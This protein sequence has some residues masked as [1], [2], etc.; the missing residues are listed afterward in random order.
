MCSIQRQRHRPNGI[1]RNRRKDRE[2]DRQ[3]RFLRVNQAYVHIKKEAEAEGLRGTFCW[4]IV[5][6]SSQHVRI[7]VGHLVW[8][9]LAVWPQA[10]HGELCVCVCVCVRSLA[11]PDRT[12]TGSRWWWQRG[13]GRRA[14]WTHTHGCTQA[15][16]PV[17][18]QSGLPKRNFNKY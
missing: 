15:A 9:H 2:T 1:E 17:V 3:T 10:G 5:Y 8:C 6:C 11:G 13:T 7:N 16:L 4:T 12:S 14:R 18:R